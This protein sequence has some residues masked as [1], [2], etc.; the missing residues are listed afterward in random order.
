MQVLVASNNLVR[1]HFLV[2][3]LR[4]AGI[5]SEILDGQMS[6]MEGGIGAIPRRLVVAADDASRARR[7]LADSGEAWS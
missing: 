6:A 4:D 2:C 7:V 5:E 1:L 3:L